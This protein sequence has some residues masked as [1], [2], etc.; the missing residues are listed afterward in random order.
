MDLGT[1]TPAVGSVRKTKRVGR[2]N[3]SGWGGIGVRL[4]YGFQNKE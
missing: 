3:A 1:L 2:G 4:D